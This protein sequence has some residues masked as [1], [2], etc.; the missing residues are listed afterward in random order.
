[1][2][3]SLKNGPHCDTANKPHLYPEI[4]YILPC[5]E[6]GRSSRMTISLSPPAPVFHSG[7]HGIVES[8]KFNR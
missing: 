8:G 2:R 7:F 6:P 5:V 4:L 3:S 1:M